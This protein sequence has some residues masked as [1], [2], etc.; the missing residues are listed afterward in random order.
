[1]KHRITAALER[2]SRAMLAPLSY[3]SAA[4]LLLVVGALLTS[5]PLAG[6]LPFL[7]WEPVQLAG[8]II[9]KCLTA[10]ISNLSVLFCTGLAAALAKRE[11]H[12]AAFIAL[13]S[14]LVY[15]TAG[16]VTLTELGLLAQPDALTGLYSAGQT[17]VLGIQTVDTGVFGGI[18]LGLLTAFVYDRTCEKAHRGILGGVFSGVRWS[19]ACMA[20]L[21]AVLGFGACFVWP[22]IQKAI[23]AVTG[24]IA[25]SGNIGLFLYGFL[26]RLL[27]PTGLHHLVYMPFQFSQLGGQLMV[28][29][30]TYTGAY[31]VMMTEY[32]LGLPFSD[33][34][35][36]MYTG[37]T[38]TFGYFGIAAAFIFCAR[39][40][41]R[42]KTALQLL[43]LAFTASLASITEP[44]DF[45]FCFSA[46]V[47]WLAHAAISGSFIV[48][49]HLCGVTAF[50][51]N[52]LGSL[53]MNLSA[54]A[55]R[56]NYPVLYL[57]GLAQIAVY[58]V[59]F[60]VLIKALDLPTPGRRP[61]EPSR[62]EKALPLDE[63]GVEKLIAA[64]GGRENIRTV[65]NCF[66]RLRV[67][68][69]DPAFVKEQALKAL[70]C[71]GV[72]QSGCDV[73]IVYG[74]RAPEVRQAV[75]RRLNR[76]KQKGLTWLRAGGA[77]QAQ[78]G[79]NEAGS[80]GMTAK[81]EKEM[82]S[83]GMVIKGFK[84]GCN[85]AYWRIYGMNTAPRKGL[86]ELGY[87]D[88]VLLHERQLEGWKK[89]L[90]DNPRRLMVKRMKPGLFTV[91]QNKEVAGRR[92]Q[93][94][95]NCFLLDIPDKVA[96]VVHRRYSE[97]DLRRL[98]EEWLACG[99]RGGVLVSAAI[100]T[101]EKEVL[102]EAMNRGYR[103][104]LLRENGFPRLYKPCGESFYACSE[105]L[106]LQISPWDYHME[107]KTITREQC[108]ELNEMAERIAEWR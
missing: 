96:V 101:K 64:F 12:Q 67:T 5:A 70:P 22:P 4:G 66:T 97:E 57:L 18:L 77:N 51:S 105:G 62:P 81:R 102:R 3:L 84:M 13:M 73:Q 103:I 56:T 52:L 78:T 69:N 38:K 86:F 47:L 30:V 40:G 17:M 68:V 44:L 94:V 53:V 26:E 54:G 50:T 63:Q 75:E 65:D 19:F 49:L 87:N 106:L 80:I 25:A 90:D 31:V 20:A 10:V 42:K 108:L 27:I 21:A 72:V 8:R 9:Y 60:T 85:K 37:F 15:L 36:W 55:A 28:G 93:M 48:L 104:V 43:P 74:I 6:V 100:S 98:R 99:E 76:L 107:K 92:C 23:A 1:M 11:K 59:V 61:E 95:G 88:K 7:R 32:N 58:F 34:I 16:N 29:S 39:R 35:V 71:S 2:F 83:L 89:Y 82:G 33:G 24:F 14:Y 79:E 41:S 91:M 46:P 45:L